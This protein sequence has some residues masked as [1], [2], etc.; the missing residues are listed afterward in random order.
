MTCF[1]KAKFTVL[2]LLLLVSS[3]A[4]ALDCNNAQTTVDMVTCSQQS[5][6]RADAELNRVYKRLRATL[7]DQGKTLLRDA[8]RAWIKY[9]DAECL[10]HRDGVRG[11]TMMPIVE[12]GC[13]EEMTIIRTQQLGTDPLTGQRYE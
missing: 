5:Y 11:G 3:P 9:R 1:Y 7:D 10:R 8:Q 2:P 4:S 13:L 12:I 6:N